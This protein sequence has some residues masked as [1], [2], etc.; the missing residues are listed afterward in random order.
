[1][2]NSNYPKY[3]LNDDNFPF[4]VV[5]YDLKNSKHIYKGDVGA[6]GGRGV[7]VESAI[8]NITTRLKPGKTLEDYSLTPEGFRVGVELEMF[9][10][11]AY[12]QHLDAI[13]NWASKKPRTPDEKFIFGGKEFDQNPNNWNMDQYWIAKD[14]ATT[15]YP[16]TWDANTIELKISEA[17]KN[18]VNELPSKST[19]G[20]TVLIGYTN[21]GIP[22]Q[23]AVE[24]TPP[25][26]FANFDYIK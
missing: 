25:S 24:N 16:S 22:I 20:Q 23:F 9:N 17:W 12:D 10:K 14:N 26:V 6:S 4:K 7:H 5:V 11:A 13:K 19:E 15:L 2:K 21:D 1:M 3:Y 8:D 18:G